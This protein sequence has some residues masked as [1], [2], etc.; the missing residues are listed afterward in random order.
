MPSSA[1]IDKLLRSV[2]DDP[3]TLLDE[4]TL[5]KFC[6]SLS[7]SARLLSECT[8]TTNPVDRAESFRYLLTMAAYAVDAGIL[9]PDPLEPMFSQ[10]YR[11]HL[12][13]WGAAS[14]DGVYRRAM[15]RDD[16]S[17]RVHG[18][19]GNASYFS[20]DFR[21]SSPAS[22]IL[23]GDLDLDRDGN[24]EV[25]IGGEARDERWWPCN[26]GTTGLVTREFFDDWLGAQRSHLRI[27]CLDGETAPRP[28][29]RASR[30]AAEF[31]VVGDW[32]LEG[33]VRFWINQSVPLEA[34]SANRFD[35]QLSRTDT[36]LPVVST[37]FWRLA[38]DEALI[39][40]F[41]DPEAAFWGLQLA[42]SLWHTLD[43]ANR[44]TTTNSAQAHR[45]PD[46][47]YRIVVAATDPGIHN[48][49]DTTGL[50]RGVL[51]LRFC[52]ATSATPP[53]TRVVNVSTVADEVPGTLRCTA[54]ERR[55]QVAARREGVAHL[56]LD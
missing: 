29:H 36:K 45:D 3:G 15:L 35:P 6:S 16:R 56:I 49:L 22:T 47:V 24:F 50:E 17:Y 42:T 19:L 20:M 30:V 44:L 33:A 13:D 14:P 10:P 21:Q 38:P 41:A 54:D 34:R 5:D 1:L 43:Y 27:E 8:L 52:E 37:G 2:A 40:E 46:G 48:W 28:E 18:R 25:F 55:T 51:I 23:R 12:L 9:N 11:L 53:S 32:I 26:P 7:E 39:V 4:H 31:D